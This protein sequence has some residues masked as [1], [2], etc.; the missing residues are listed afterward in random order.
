VL[1]L[2]VYRTYP[3]PDCP[4]K[5]IALLHTKPTTNSPRSIS[6]PLTRS[7]L[8]SKPMA[9]V[10][11]RCDACRLG[12][13]LVVW[14]CLPP[15]SLLLQPLASAGA[16]GSGKMVTQ[17]SVANFCRRAAIRPVTSSVTRR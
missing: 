5:R 14:M 10:A 15:P 3:E 4:C 2:Q 16:V 6:R 9:L 1:P 8:F 11:V 7:L 13:C 12:A 17:R